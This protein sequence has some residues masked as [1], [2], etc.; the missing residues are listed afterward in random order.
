M[1]QLAADLAAGKR[2]PPRTVVITFDDGYRDGYLSAAPILKRYGMVGTFFVI[3]GRVG[4]SDYLAPMELCQMTAQGDEIANHS[5]HHVDLAAQSRKRLATE[6]DTAA[7]QIRKWT[8]IAPVTL[9]YPFGTTSASVIAK[10][11]TD[12]Y[13]LAVTNVEGALES[14]SSRFAVPRVRVGPGMSGAGLLGR[15]APYAGT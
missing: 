14:W 11:R 4:D 7:S 5:V 6:I 9:A 15:L 2:E 10:V 8:G 12:G 3:T 1:R 13:W